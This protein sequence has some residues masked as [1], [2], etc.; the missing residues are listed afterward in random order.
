MSGFSLIELMVSMALG[1]FLT[2]IAFTLYSSTAEIYAQNEQSATLLED[3][4]YAMQLLSSE[5]KMTGFYGNVTSPTDVDDT[6]MDDA[7]M[8]TTD[9]GTLDD[10]AT[11]AF[12]LDPPVETL[13]YA[14]QGEV[15]TTYPCIDAAEVT[16]S[17]M[18]LAIKRVLGTEQAFA[19]LDNGSV[20][21]GGTG[22]S[23]TLFHMDVATADLGADYTYW[24]YAVSIFYVD[25][26]SGTPML[27]RKVLQSGTPNTMTT[28]SSPVA[29]GVE[30]LHVTFGIDSDDDGS[31]NYYLST[32]TDTERETAVSARIFILSRSLDAD[33]DYTNTK[34][35]VL[36]D[37]SVGPF[38][39]NYYRKV[40]STTVMLRNPRNY[41]TST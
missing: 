28:E 39:D 15:I 25:D 8:I 18:I 30:R 35:Y 14:S 32:P 9:C 40:F 16:S 21:V 20:Y 26:S 36:G 1:L 2:I 38:N 33:T 5:L 19:D 31:A 4:R 37:T 10:K 17:G 13:S 12:D 22:T 34:T 29:E 11:W 27:Y 41:M 23:G 6:E 3:T 24:E 7:S